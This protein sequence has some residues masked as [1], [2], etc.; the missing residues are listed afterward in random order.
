MY[1]I[2]FEGGL[3]VKQVVIMMLSLCLVSC[4]S[5]S[6]SNVVDDPDMLLSMSREEL[7]EYYDVS[8]VSGNPRVALGYAETRK[9]DGKEVV[10]ISTWESNPDTALELILP[11][12]KTIDD[13]K[14]VYCLLVD[15]TT[16]C[17]M[18]D[19]V[20]VH[21]WLIFRKKEDERSSSKESY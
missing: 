12:G 18:R 3:C 16:T 2:L 4:S 1:G 10:F 11:A 6:S 21:Y 15:N 14:E 7:C 19:D 17:D 9:Q 5:V 13:V 20:L 8:K